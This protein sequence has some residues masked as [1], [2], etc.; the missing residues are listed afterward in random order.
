MLMKKYIKISALTIAATCFL[1]FS[2]SMAG[3]DSSAQPRI[4]NPSTMTLSR[5]SS[6]MD[7]SGVTDD[8][9]NYNLLTC[10]TSP[11]C[12]DINGTYSTA[13]VPTVTTTV[14]VC[15]ANFGGSPQA[16]YQ[17]NCNAQA[18]AIS[19]TQT[20]VTT[21]QTAWNNYVNWGYP[22]LNPYCPD[23]CTVARIVTP[24]YPQLPVTSVVNAICPDGYAE[25]GFFNMQPQL[26][27]QA[28]NTINAPVT[29]SSYQI[30]INQGYNCDPTASA[31][32]SFDMCKNGAYW[33]TGGTYSDY[34]IWPWSVV[35]SRPKDFVQ[36][37]NGNAGVYTRT[38][39]VTSPYTV[40]YGAS[41]SDCQN[42]VLS[43]QYP[44]DG[45]SVGAGAYSFK[46]RF[47]YK[48]YNCVLP[49]GYV[50]GSSLVP[51][52]VV[53]TRIK[54]VWQKI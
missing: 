6:T 14:Q 17:T 23:Q 28:G 36:N 54:P 47:Y 35:V 2:A 50:Y 41:S 9:Y 21:L 32:N 25:V 45:W 11:V 44:G 16:G 34:V 27:W 33:S 53:C 31:E 26:T 13:N 7:S 15:P 19:P 22:N 37:I 43:A 42:P 51:T 5:P 12:P 24:P 20:W 48:Y 8:N 40:Y 3:T 46:A 30:L 49:S 38:A 1:P 29:M 39:N 52:S 18:Q 4:T 10:P